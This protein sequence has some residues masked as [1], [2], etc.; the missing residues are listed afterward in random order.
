[1]TT[2]RWFQAHTRI[3]HGKIICWEHPN[4]ADQI[5]EALDDVFLRRSVN[6]WPMAVPS[7]DLNLIARLIYEKPS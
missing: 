2:R 1:M 6:F 5:V 4:Y 7:V 3:D